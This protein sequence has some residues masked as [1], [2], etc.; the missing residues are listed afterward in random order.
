MSEQHYLTKKQLADRLGVS[1]QTVER[2][3]RR[4]HLT[5]VKVGRCVR[6]PEFEIDRYLEIAGLKREQ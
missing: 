3:M 4:G 2:E 1:V 6:I 5:G